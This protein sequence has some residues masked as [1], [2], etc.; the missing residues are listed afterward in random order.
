[1]TK[2][3]IMNLKASKTTIG[4]R[5]RLADAGGNAEVLKEALFEQA[6]EFLRDCAQ[7]GVFFVDEGETISWMLDIPHDRSLPKT[8]DRAEERKSVAIIGE[9]GTEEKVFFLGGNE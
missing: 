3:E 7:R 5:G 6:V 9:D 8:P 1:M 2:E 4:G